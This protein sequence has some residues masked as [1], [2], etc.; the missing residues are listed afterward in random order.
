MKKMIS[1]VLVLMAICAV[2]TVTVSADSGPKPE[3]VFSLTPAEG[4]YYAALLYDK[5][6]SPY[7]Y[8]IGDFGTTSYMKKNEKEMYEKLNAYEDADGYNIAEEVWY[9]QD[10]VKEGYVY[11]P[12]AKYKLLVYFPDS[13]RYSVIESNGHYAIFMRYTVTVSADGEI[14]MVGHTSAAVIDNSPAQNLDLAVFT[15]ISLIVTILVE[16]LIGLCFRFT[17]GRQILTI[18]L[19]N[20][21]TLPL[22]TG[23][24]YTI[25]PPVYGTIFSFPYAFFEIGV[26]VVEAAVYCLLLPKF[27]KGRKTPRWLVALYAVVANLATYAIA[28]FVPHLPSLILEA[29][30]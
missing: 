28:A 23:L 26:A 18:I 29:I 24:I 8:V 6:E 4:D 27:A 21:I 25:N 11:N 14:D 16:L 20:V 30:L 7:V 3:L 17:K 10:S 15:F 9:V 1:I 2:A 5:D 19:V 12:P 13:D 22:M